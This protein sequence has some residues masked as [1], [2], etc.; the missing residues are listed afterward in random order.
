MLVVGAPGTGKKMLVN[1]VCNET[2]ANLF[3]LTPSN[4]DGKYPGKKAYEMVH[5]VF[6][7]AKVCPARACADRP[8]A[9]EM[10]MLHPKAHAAPGGACCTRRRCSWRSGV[11]P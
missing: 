6:K 11:R 3:N 7:G 5:T 9:R 8:A 2:G 10:R 1:A 4:T